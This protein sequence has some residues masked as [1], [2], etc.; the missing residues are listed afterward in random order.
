[1]YRPECTLVSPE[2]RVVQEVG[3]QLLREYEERKEGSFSEVDQLVYLRAM[4]PALPLRLLVGVCEGYEEA[5]RFLRLCLVFAVAQAVKDF[6]VGEA[7]PLELAE[8]EPSECAEM[9]PVDFPEGYQAQWEPR[10]VEG[11]RWH[12]PE[13]WEGESRFRAVCCGNHLP[14]D[15]LGLTKEELYASGAESL[16]VKVAITFAA[17][18]KN[19]IGVTIDVKSAFLYAPIWGDTKGTD[20]RIIVKPPYLLVELGLLGKDD[21]RW[22]RKALYGLPTSP[23]D[24]GRYRDAEFQKIRIA[25]QDREYCL[26]QTKTDDAL[27]LLRELDANGMG[28][29]AGVLVVYVDDLAVFAPKGLAK[30]F[31]LA[32]Q[33]RWKTSEPEWLGSKPVTFCGIELSLLPTGYRMSQCAYIRE[34]LNRYGIEEHA[35]AP[36]LKWVEPER[37][38][39]P[40]VEE[41]REAQGLT[42][43]LLWVSTRTRLAM[44]ATIPQVT[45]QPLQEPL[46]EEVSDQPVKVFQEEDPRDPFTARVGT[47]SFSLWKQGME[48]GFEEDYEPSSPEELE[49]DQGGNSVV[50]W[51]DEWIEGRKSGE[52]AQAQFPVDPETHAVVCRQLE[53][54][55]AALAAEL[56]EAEAAS[57]RRD[58]LLF[59][60]NLEERHRQCQRQ[61]DGYEARQRGGAVSARAV[62]EEQRRA[63]KNRRGAERVQSFS[64]GTAG[65]Y[66][67]FGRF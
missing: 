1:H 31:I 25:W 47:L 65:F 53:A 32:I 63:R 15:K 9:L 59:E 4:F 26:V 61:L 41:V 10:T 67:V 51:E 12:M 43:A 18:H 5:V 35:T 16:S 64:C 22:V 30:E 6:R 50:E 24:W 45:G 8:Y 20:E 7:E 34:L 46:E 3:L 23:R 62:A 11:E 57:A 48:D 42:G 21:R 54:A 2:N 28:S 38:D 37:V 58:E 55:N 60:R 44:L 40:S 13:E 36:I 66:G 56:G 52:S 29:I 14:T 17:R 19:W 27:W 39:N 49:A 33:T